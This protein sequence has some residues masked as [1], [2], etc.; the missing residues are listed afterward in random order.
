MELMI[1]DPTYAASM[2]LGEALI[3]ACNRGQDGAGAFA[4]AEEN[5]IDLFLGDP[6]F[7]DYIKTH[8]YELVVGTDSITDPKAVARL[9]AYCKLYH[10][11]WVPAQQQRLLI[12]LEETIL[13]LN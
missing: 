11:L 1:Q 8:K 10:N 13:E 2:R 5:G 6:D 4:F 3:D 12:N 9:R 7:S